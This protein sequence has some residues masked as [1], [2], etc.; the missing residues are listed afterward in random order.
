MEIIQNNLKDIILAITA[1]VAAA[2]AV[3]ALTPTPKDDFAIGKLKGFLRIAY[4]I[5]D[6]LAL[7][8]GKAKDK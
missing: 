3:A 7:N 4:K 5:M 1:T 6:V 2:S 8:V